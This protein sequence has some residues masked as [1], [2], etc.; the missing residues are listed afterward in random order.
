MPPEREK[1]VEI[2]FPLGGIDLSMGYTMQRPGTTPV[3]INVR[4]YDSGTNRL[5]G[6]T[7]P[8]LTPFFGKGSTSQVAGFHL[9]Q[10]LTCIV[11]VSPSAVG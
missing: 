7:R 3:A 6:G 4:G 9:I 2:R 8:G 11:W 10:S 5:R 1:T